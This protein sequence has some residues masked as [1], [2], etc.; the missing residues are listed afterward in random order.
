M[1]TWGLRS[2][3]LSFLG[4][5]LFPGGSLLRGGRYPFI[6]DISALFLLKDSMGLSP[7]LL[8][9]NSLSLTCCWKSRSICL[10]LSTG[11]EVS[12][13]L[14]IFLFSRS[15]RSNSRFL[16]KKCRV[17]SFEVGD[18]FSAVVYTEVSKSFLLVELPPDMVCLGEG[19]L[20]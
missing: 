9:N 3:L 16:A 7:L 15:I 20:E 8:V 19:L 18:Y 1:S 10:R 5:C 14:L 12:M 4:E 17:T 11:L 6:M 13:C 2:L